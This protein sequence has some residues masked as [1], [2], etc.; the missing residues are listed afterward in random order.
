MAAEFVRL[1]F[2]LLGFGVVDVAFADGGLIR[3]SRTEV[4]QQRPKTASLAFAD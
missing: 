2:V 3:H 4:K 1:D